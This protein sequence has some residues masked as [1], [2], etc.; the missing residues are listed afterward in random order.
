MR[1]IFIYILFILELNI[2]AC[3]EEPKFI[4]HDKCINILYRAAKTYFTDNEIFIIRDSRGIILRFGIKSPKEEYI[5]ISP[6]TKNKL[7]KIGDFLAK[8]ENPVIIEVHTVTAEPQNS[9]NEKNWEISAVIAGNIEHEIIYNRKS[10]NSQ[11]HSV[12]YG[13]FL[14]ENNTPNNGGKLLN[15]VDIIILCN[16]NGE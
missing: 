9:I 13:E 8:I 14:P 16:I 15:R 4:L 6:E 11:I 10:L 1:K 3:A 12:G 5:K 2:S 7:L